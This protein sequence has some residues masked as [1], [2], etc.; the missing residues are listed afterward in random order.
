M[1]QHMYV[2]PVRC[3]LCRT[4]FDLWYDLQENLKEEGDGGFVSQCELGKAVNQSLCWR[5]RKGM[6]RTIIQKINI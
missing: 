6:A 5:C 2:L 3:G 4:V 1:K